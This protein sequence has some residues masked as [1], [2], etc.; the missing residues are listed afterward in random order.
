MKPT[1]TLLPAAQHAYVSLMMD[2]IG[3]GLTSA[4]QID[5]EVHNET[6]GFPTGFVIRMT[7]FPNGPSFTAQ[8]QQN[9]SLKLLK[10]FEQKPDLTVMFKHMSHAFL[11]FSFQ[12]G[13]ARAFAHDRIVADGDVSHAIRLV[14]CLNKMESLI[15]PKL[16]AQRAVKQYP[17]DLDLKKK[18]SLA[19]RIYLKVAQTY[20]NR[21]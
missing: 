8:S 20:I 2:I 12:E 3:R 1:K 7:V 10:H 17:Q 4:S 21:S 5:P 6:Q 19:S 13:T 16:I 9:G 11:V 15:L 18:I 14:R